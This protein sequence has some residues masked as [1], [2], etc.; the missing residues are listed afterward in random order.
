[1]VRILALT[2]LLSLLSLP[3]VAGCDPDDAAAPTADVHART[4]RTL[5]VDARAPAGT[6][7]VRFVLLSGDLVEAPP[8]IDA[9]TED[10]PAGVTVLRRVLLGGVDATRP[11]SFRDVAE[12]NYTVCAAVGLVSGSQAGYEA[13]VEAA[14]A[15]VGGGTELDA[16]KLKAAA[17]LLKKDPEFV[18]TKTDW[19]AA[20]LRCQAVEVT[21]D[22][23]SRQVTIE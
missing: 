6:S 13:K 7:K 16:D 23:A 1:M 9:L 21:A 20:P 11:A 15:A 5:K 22:P 18:V 17:E 10:P 19:S 12:G 2:A 14:Y 3:M 4:D 8:D